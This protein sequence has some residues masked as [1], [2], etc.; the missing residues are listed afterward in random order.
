MCGMTQTL[1]ELN[2]LL[3]TV[4]AAISKLMNGER[5][6]RISHGDSM[7]EYGQAKLKDLQEYKASLV[8][9]INALNSRPRHYRIAT[10]KGV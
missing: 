5:V 3:E 1:T 9:S 6:T 4:D 8:T 2:E 7:A 10:S